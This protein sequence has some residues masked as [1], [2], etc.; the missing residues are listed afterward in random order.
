MCVYLFPAKGETEASSKLSY[1]SW[2]FPK[3]QITERGF[4]FFSFDRMRQDVV[5]LGVGDGEEK[6]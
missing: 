4:F 6:K 1:V 5:C 2:R 3:Y